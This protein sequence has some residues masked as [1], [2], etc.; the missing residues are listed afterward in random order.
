METPAQYAFERYGGMSKGFR[1]RLIDPAQISNATRFWASGWGVG[2][3]MA[4][5]R[6]LFDAIGG[7]DVALDVGTS[8]AGGGDIEFFY[9]TV[10]SGHMLRYEPAALVRHIDRRDKA[11]L[12]RQIYNNGR[13]FPAYLLT[14]ARNEPQRRPTILW[15]ALR[16]WIWGHLLRNILKG[17]KSR[18]IGRLRLALAELRGAASSFSA[19]REAQR[20]ARQQLERR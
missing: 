2:A 17:V 14:I 8:T 6:S 12:R 20:V 10:S 13:S 1:S 18:N 11:A 16:H 7:F 3:N 5:R 19:Y 9:R 4:F 15:F